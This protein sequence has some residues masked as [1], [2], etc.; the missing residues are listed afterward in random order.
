MKCQIC[1][2]EITNEYFEG[3]GGPICAECL[4]KMMSYHVLKQ[5]DMIKNIKGD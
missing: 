1:E 4:K 5:L 3:V 2:K